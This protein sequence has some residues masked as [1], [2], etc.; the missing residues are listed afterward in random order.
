MVIKIIKNRA[1][2]QAKLH[3]NLIA[4]LIRVG[5]KGRTTKRVGLAF[6]A[7]LTVWSIAT[8][9]AAPIGLS[10][11]EVVITA[12]QKQVLAYLFN[13]GDVPITLR[14]SLTDLKMTEGGGLELVETP[15]DGLDQNE[16]KD[17]FAAN[18]LRIVP[19]ILEI[20]AGESHI[21][22]FLRRPKANAPKGV[23]HTHLNVKILPSLDEFIKRQSATIAPE[24]ENKLAINVM[25]VINVAFPVWLETIP[26]DAAT[27]TAT[28]GDAE[29]ITL[30]DGRNK[31]SAMLNRV[32][33][34]RLKGNLV[35]YFKPDE[36][37]P[38]TV[39]SSIQTIA[40]YPEVHG[41][42]IIAPIS[43]DLLLKAN[44]T[45]ADLLSSGGTLRVEFQVSIPEG[46]TNHPTAS[47]R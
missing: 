47:L 30:P 6:L 27:A 8:A 20:P 7:A 40:I 5:I 32:G 46:I 39:I 11:G 10:P 14:L 9:S 13:Y 34:G 3:A 25:P 22:K 24:G 35:V 15:A 33:E 29:L 42:K 18:K 19:Q 28:I 44:L 36:N 37:M 31:V 38:E 45:E 43:D 26:A 2:Y 41:I 17:H 23:Y 1:S 4:L 12:N 16:F 21:I